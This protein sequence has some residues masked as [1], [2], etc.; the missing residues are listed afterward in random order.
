LRPTLIATEPVLGVHPPEAALLFCIMS[1]VGPYYKTGFKPVSLYA[2]PV[3][4]R[5]WPGGTG[6]YKL[7]AN[8]APGIL[9]ALEAAKKGYHQ[10]LWLNGENITEVGTMNLFC[11][12]TNKQGQKELI[13]AD[14]DGTIL[15][16]VTRKS[17][18]E[19]TREWKEFNVA[20]RSWTIT[21]L[22]AALEEN[23]VLEMFGA[24]T[25]AIVSPVHKINYKG[26]DYNVPC[27]DGVAGELSQRLMKHI[28]D[29]Q[30]GDVK[31]AWSVVI[32]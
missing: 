29:I 2:D 8:Y 9:P 16:G 12:W 14:L 3:N 11:F 23:R 7:G 18:L 5:A 13:T 1:P 10:I 6:G 19:L 32:N 27:K 21:E 25:A 17:I 24:G 20:E 28:M 15:P 30:Y 31:H 4:V 22:M 26:I